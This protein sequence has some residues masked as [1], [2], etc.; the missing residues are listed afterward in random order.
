MAAKDVEKNVFENI[1]RMRGYSINMIEARSF[2][3]EKQRRG[4]TLT[5]NTC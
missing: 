4:R 1:Y 5:M 2:Q 3:G